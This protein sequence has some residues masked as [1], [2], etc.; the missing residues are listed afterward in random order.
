[1]RYFNC[2]F[3]AVWMTVRRGGVLI[4]QRSWAGP[5][6]HAMWAPRLPADLPVQH[7]TPEDKSPGLH[8]EPLFRG[9]VEHR[10]GESHSNPPNGFNWVFLLF[11]LGYLIAFAAGVAAM[12]WWAYQ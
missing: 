6:L 2:L 9:R 8:L 10:V 12:A 7:F 5:Y 3:F 11:W 1:M 4:L